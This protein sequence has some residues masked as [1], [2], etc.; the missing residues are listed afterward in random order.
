MQGAFYEMESSSIPQLDIPIWQCR[1]S[2]SKWLHIDQPE[3]PF[4]L[5]TISSV[6]SAGRLAMASIGARLKRANGCI[7]RASLLSRTQATL[8]KRCFA[9]SG[10]RRYQQSPVTCQLAQVPADKYQRTTI[11][12]DVRRT[13]ARGDWGDPRAS[14]VSDT[15]ITDASLIDPT[16]R[17][18]TVN[19]V[20]HHLVHSALTSI[21]GSTAS[22]CTW[23]TSAHP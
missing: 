17:H 19:F 8:S 21:A 10:C 22:S 16:I 11:T 7:H 1:L 20:L 18:F 13:A 2:N 15:E 5:T 4:G 12:E 6:P 23:C 14:A 9:T 3:I